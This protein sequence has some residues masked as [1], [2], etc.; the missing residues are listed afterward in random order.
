MLKSNCFSNKE[1]GKPLH[2]A[3]CVKYT[4]SSLEARKHEGS[5]VQEHAA[6]D[7]STISYLHEQ[8]SWGKN[9]SLYVGGGSHTHSKKQ[10][11]RESF[12]KPG[13]MGTSEEIRLWVPRL[14]D[15]AYRG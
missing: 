13:F 5:M 7:L 6:E 12:H 11:R 15:I 2:R 14:S 3:G 1:P 8:S 4:K 10:K 9:V